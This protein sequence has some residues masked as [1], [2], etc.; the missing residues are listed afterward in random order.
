[1][2]PY[3]LNTVEWHTWECITVGM[4]Y[5]M[6]IGWFSQFGEDAP[7]PTQSVFNAIKAWSK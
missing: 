5:E 4:G 6:T 3:K 1:M 2:N 7:K